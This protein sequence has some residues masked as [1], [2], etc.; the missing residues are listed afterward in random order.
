MATVEEITFKTKCPEEEYHT[1]QG[2]LLIQLPQN[3]TL[4]YKTYKL[5]NVNSN[6]KPQTPMLLPRIK[7]PPNETNKK[8]IQPLR[9]ENIPLEDLHKLGRQIQAISPLSTDFESHHARNWKLWVSIG[10]IMV[11]VAS[12]GIHHFRPYL[13]KKRAPPEPEATPSVL[14]RPEA[15]S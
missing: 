13:K 12:S 10:I 5:G 4:E 9:I 6:H 11:I 14:F 7:N 3:C 1:V 8:P 15:V 2:E